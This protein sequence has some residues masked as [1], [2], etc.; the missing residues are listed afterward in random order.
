LNQ[1]INSEESIMRLNIVLSAI[2]FTLVFIVC[3]EAGNGAAPAGR[4]WIKNP[5]IVQFDTPEDIFAIGDPHGDPERLAGAL[6]AAKLIDGAPV[7]SDSVKWAGGRSVLVV[8]GDLIDKWSD[9]LEVIA[10]LQRLQTDAATQGG[11]VIITMGNHEAEFLAEPLGRKTKEF[12]SE[13]KGAGM[14]PVETANCYG[15]IGQF[16]CGL[17]IAAR[18][19]DWFFSH[20]GN[21]KGKTPEELTAVIESGFAKDGF[22]TGELVGADSILEARLSKKGP[23][24]LP[25]FQGGNFSTDPEKLLAEYVAKLGVKHLV[26]GHQYGRVTFPDGESRKEEHFFQ[27]YGILFLV[28]TGMSQG[29]EES[30]S[31]GGALRI[32]GAASAQR[33]IVICANGEQKTLWSN[34]TSDREQKHCSE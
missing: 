26:Q 18:V 10:L 5:A 4:D 34:E 14:D 33:A 11:K 20:G 12:S 15:D 17:P 32:T 3:S 13:L 25:W 23:G 7:V 27:R 22:S 24:G 21:T 30:D 28:D 1:R 29:I 9:S 2:G 31:T 16:L 6:A 19:N 8:T